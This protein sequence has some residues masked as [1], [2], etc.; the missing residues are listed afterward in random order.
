MTTDTY[1]GYRL[2]P[3][4]VNQFV[5]SMQSRTRASLQSAEPLFEQ[6]NTFTLY[7]V[8]LLLWATGHR[9]VRDPFQNRHN[10]SLAQGLIE[11]TDKVVDE[12]LAYRV[13]PLCPLAIRQITRYVEHLQCYQNTL[14]REGESGA[15]LHNAIE[16][17]LNGSLHTPFFFLINENGTTTSI[18][19][20]A[21]EQ[22]WAPSLALKANEGR[23][24]L[25][26]EL[27]IAGVSQSDILCMLGHT[28][29]PEHPFGLRAET[30]AKAV[31]TR[32]SASIDNI[33]TAAGWDILEGFSFYNTTSLPPYEKAPPV[34]PHQS[35][36]LGQALR[37]KRRTEKQHRASVLVAEA[38]A[39]LKLSGAGPIRR[40]Q[41][42]ELITLTRE[43][44]ARHSDH[45]PINTALAEWFLA[46]QRRGR[47]VETIPIKLNIDVEPSPFYAGC[48]RDFDDACTTRDRFVEIMRDADKNA[49]LNSSDQR[50]AALILGLALLEQ[51]SNA[52][53]LRGLIHSIAST[54]YCTNGV[55]H[56]EVY[57]AKSSGTERTWLGR[58][59]PTHDITMGLHL[60]L[61]ANHDALS[62]IT[63]AHVERRLVEL[64]AKL[65]VKTSRKNAIDTLAAFA[66]KLSL[67]EHAGVNRPSRSDAVG[68]SPIP[69]QAWCRLLTSRV[70]SQI[71][72]HEPD[73]ASENRQGSA[74]L[75]RVT[76]QKT[77]G[78]AISECIRHFRHSFNRIAEQQGN[79]EF[80][81]SQKAVNEALANS[82][83]QYIEDTNHI[84]LVIRLIA[85]WG[86]TLC[87]NGTQ[88][89]K[90]PATATLD[91]YIF[92]LLNSLGYA[93]QGEFSL[94]QDSEEFEQLYSRC[95]DYGQQQEQSTLVEQLRHF[96]HY[97][98]DNFSVEQCDWSTIWSLASSADS[99]S[100]ANF[101]TLAEYQR[102]LDIIEADPTLTSR[103][104]IQCQT[105]VILCYRFGLRFGE[106]YHLQAR[107]IQANQDL[108]D[109]CLLIRHTHRGRKKSD[110]GVRVTPLL[111]PLAE[112]EITILRRCIDWVDISQ[113]DDTLACLMLAD[114]ET[115]HLLDRTWL[116]HYLNSALKAAT[117]D[118]SVKFHHTRHSFATR[119][120]A[121]IYASRLSNRKAFL[122][123]WQ[124]ERLN[125][126]ALSLDGQFSEPL[127]SLS[128]YL[129]HVDSLQAIRTYIHVSDIGP[130]RDP[131]A[132]AGWTGRSIAALIGEKY[133]TYKVRLG[134]QGL[135]QGAA[136]FSHVVAHATERAK[137]PAL[138]DKH[139]TDYSPPELASKGLLPKDNTLSPVIIHQLLYKLVTRDRG[140]RGLAGAL[141]LP[142]QTI[143][144]IVDVAI[145]IEKTSGFDDLRLYRF[146]ADR[147][148]ALLASIDK[149]ASN[150][151]FLT[152][153][154]RLVDYFRHLSPILDR[155]EAS[156]RAALATGLGTWRHCYCQRERRLI[157]DSDAQLAHLA[158]LMKLL[159]LSG[160]L[161]QS[162]NAETAKILDDIDAKPSAGRLKDRRAIHRSVQSTLSFALI[163]NKVGTQRALF[164]VFF[165]LSIWERVRHDAIRKV[166]D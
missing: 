81:N 122:H 158:D 82:L 71:E 15:S 162:A 132:L 107:H 12:R 63:V 61:M 115:R 139:Y 130:E 9:P 28:L 74:W 3:D 127:R 102:A 99:K 125:I 149:E 5:A 52:D 148:D 140:Y 93:C 68:L 88:R 57:S 48:V 106:A 134:R 143:K 54:S 40:K 75:P 156:Q 166:K 39:Q 163:D 6:H 70:P 35:E 8:S 161:Q 153:H 58:W 126:S 43:L 164:K 23:R 113:T 86:Y 1:D 96:H 73:S 4:Q 100:S 30:S 64:L 85:G 108:S 76:Q 104:R 51:W 160:R 137:L 44:A 13:V 129:G 103:E 123:R 94:D 26:T 92:L 79:G 50:L 38:T 22:F 87:L 128:D 152:E 69:E 121:A 135:P 165:V 80:G 32:L 157:L 147:R 24:F 31:F 19:E 124:A 117:G 25:A 16:C 72:H 33:L 21:I 97:L 77:R 101:I 154:H 60:G 47:R 131:P 67:F 18:S 136:S 14:A 56:T 159:G 37:Q 133:N 42:L 27:A 29:S 138:D 98:V 90:V 116:N 59:M 151:S 142:E 91:K 111:E 83:R 141:S 65:D 118:P 11:I 110:A 114:F 53:L 112:R 7:V 41:G 95:V 20:L 145:D 66:Q 119:V 10:L 46:E 84:P 55:L 78:S 146:S 89:K 105:V 45:L 62:D 144:R 2:S 36:L 49:V 155:L 150:R 109:I 34:A 120:A 17:A